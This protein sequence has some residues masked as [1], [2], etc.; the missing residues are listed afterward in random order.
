M[1]RSLVAY[2]SGGRGVASSNLVIPT[3]KEPF[4]NVKGFCFYR[5][6]TRLKKENKYYPTEK[7]ESIF[8]GEHTTH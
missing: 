5:V 1:W 8:F 3:G 4:T 7:S 6:Q 2:S